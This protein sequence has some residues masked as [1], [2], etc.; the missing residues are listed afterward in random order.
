MI[1]GL[2]NTSIVF[3]VLLEMLLRRPCR[4]RAGGVLVV[5]ILVLLEML[6]RQQIFTFVFEIV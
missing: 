3:L 6:L 2:I 1:E 4:H 5:S